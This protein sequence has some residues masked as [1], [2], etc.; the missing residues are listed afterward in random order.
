MR[1]TGSLVSS[2]LS[3]SLCASKGFAGPTDPPEDA[4]RALSQSQNFYIFLNPSILTESPTFFL[5]YYNTVKVF[6]HNFK[7]LYEKIRRCEKYTVQDMVNKKCWYILHGY[8]LYLFVQDFSPKTPL[9]ADGCLLRSQQ[10]FRAWITISMKMLPCIAGK[11][12][13]RPCHISRPITTVQSH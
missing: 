10:W 2:P 5:W 7:F 12:V 13:L 11:E 8:T 9:L 4:H 6:L 1:W 3:R